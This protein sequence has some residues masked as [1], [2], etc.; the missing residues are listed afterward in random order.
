M[1]LTRYGNVLATA[2]LVFSV[3]RLA[4]AQIWSPSIG[5]CLVVGATLLVATLGDKMPG[6]RPGGPQALAQKLREIML[7]GLTVGALAVITV[8]IFRIRAFNQWA[9]ELFGIQIADV[10]ALAL[11][12]GLFFGWLC[13]ALGFTRPLGLPLLAVPTLLALSF[14]TAWPTPL[15]VIPFTLCLALSLA[16]GDRRNQGRRRATGYSSLVIFR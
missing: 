2:L 16:A 7:V 8:T 4:Q 3:E 9:G 6:T 15:L 11:V 12:G 1:F 13:V 10:A 14:V 5:V